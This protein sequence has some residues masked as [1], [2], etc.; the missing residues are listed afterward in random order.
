MSFFHVIYDY[1][2]NIHYELYKNTSK[3]IL[4]ANKKI[5][6]LYKF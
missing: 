5:K 6:Q 4:I 2:P 3:E 1:N